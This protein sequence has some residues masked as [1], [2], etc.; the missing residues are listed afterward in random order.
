MSE[1]INSDDQLST[2][3]VYQPVKK[4]KTI[5]KKNVLM[6]LMLL[7]WG[8][9]AQAQTK[10][11]L[12]VPLLDLPQNTQLPHRYPSMHQALQWS[13][14]V[15]DVSFWGIDAA[16]NALFD[17]KWTQTGFSYATGLLFSKYGSELP[18]PL[19]VWG[20]EEYHRSVLGANGIDSKNGNW[21]FH[22]WDGTVYGPSDQDLANLKATDNNALLYAYTAGVQ[23]ETQLTKTSV[24]NDFYNERSFYKAPLYLY[25]AHYVWNYFR[26]ATSTHSDSVKV[27]APKFEHK[28]ATQRD[29]A[30]ADLTA[31]A[32]DMFNPDA[33][34]YDRDDFPNGEGENRRIG[35]H[36][37]SEEAQQYLVKQKR[38]SLL[39][40]LNP[41]IILVNRIRINEELTILPFVQYSP[42]H[43]GNSISLN[44]PF[45]YKGDGYY[46]GVN[47]YAN[48]KHAYY[49][50]EAGV[51]QRPIDALQGLS[52]SCTVKI[53]KQP[54]SFF[55]SKASWGGA[56]KWGVSYAVADRLALTL[57]VTGKTAGWL[58]GNPYLKRNFNPVLGFQYIVPGLNSGKL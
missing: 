9:M 21:I 48:Y 43:F 42:T 53:W 50:M 10:L 36:D 18:L 14:D 20:H 58:E 46:L 27:I 47:R 16:S 37:L 49:G 3:S 13:A 32:Y 23:Y 41:A 31:W 17:K 24:M 45:T 57:D 39:N 26:F 5:M 1:L 28:E 51:Y 4:L 52:M 6:G 30:G 25:N 54:N 38:L 22:R 35:F 33:S 2:P 7:G 34:Y 56:I 19:G 44:M 8:T 29:F 15:Y 55:G 40:F 11:S 12:S